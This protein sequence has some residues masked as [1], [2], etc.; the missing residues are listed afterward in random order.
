LPSPS[1][2]LKCRVISNPTQISGSQLWLDGNDVDGDGISEGAGETFLPSG[3]ATRVDKS[4]AGSN[5][6][7]Q[8]TANNQ[9]IFVA[10]GLNSLGVVRFDGAA[11]GDGDQLD[12]PNFASGF[13]SA[14]GFLVFVSSGNGNA[15]VGSRNGAA[16]DFGTAGGSNHFGGTTPELYDDFGIATR[17]LMHSPVATGSPS[18]Y[19]ALITG[20]GGSQFVP[21]YNTSLASGGSFAATAAFSSAPR[22]GS[23]TSTTFNGDIAEVIIY[24]RPLSDG[25]LSPY[26]NELNDVWFYLQEKWNL[27]L[28]LEATPTPVIPEPSSALLLGLGL[29]GLAK[30]RRRRDK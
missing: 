20:G 19:T 27:N 22:L 4:S 23:T 1:D 28:G 9:P 16:W 13:T 29:L 15:N 2:R 5:N 3:T 21:Y 26:D 7:T 6:A 24:N 8:G 17:P 18:L 11:S 14:T 30:V 10:T 12:M 25:S